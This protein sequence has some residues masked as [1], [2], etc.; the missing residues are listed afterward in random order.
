[1]IDWRNH[2]LDWLV[3][4]CGVLAVIAGV[5]WLALWFTGV[6]GRWSA[7][8]VIMKTNMALCLTLAGISLLLLSG[9]AA[10]PLRRWAAA[11]PAALVLL[12][13]VLTFSEHLFDY[14]LGIDQ[15]LATEPPGAMG[16]I[17]P[18]RFGPPGSISLVL[19]GLGLLALAAV[20][21]RWAAYL[22]L[23]VCLINL[24]PLIGFLYGITD[25]YR[26]PRFTGI[27]WPT[28]VTLLALGSGLMLAARDAGP[29][30]LL[31]RADPGGAMLRR[32]LP[33]V[34]LIPLV[35]G[36]V[37]I[38]AERAGLL[39]S[40][41]RM[42]LLVIALIVAFSAVVWYNAMHLSR[43]SA[44]RARTEEA[45][46]ESEERFHT[47]F[48]SM[49]EGFALCEMIFDDAG[50]PC[51][52]RYLELNRAWED[53]TG[54]PT[55]GV[56][57]KRVREILPNI[58]S[59]WIEEYGKVVLTGLP[60]RLE[61][62][63]QDVDRYIQV[64][65]Y[66][67]APG[68]FAAIFS[69]VTERKQAEAERE[70][71][72]AEVQRRAAELTATFDSIAD[73]LAIYDREG[74]L[75]FMNGTAERMIGYTPAERALSLEERVQ[76]VRMARPDGTPIPYE[77]S[78]NYRA[79]QG[80]TVR[81][82]VIVLQRQDRS[83]WLSLSAAP[84]RMPDGT[85]VGSVISFTDITPLHELREHER[86][87]L[88]ILAHNLRVPATL[89]KGNLELLL[90]A[91]QPHDLVQPHRH[92]VDALHSGLQRMNT[93]IDDFLLVTR[94]EEGKITLN[95]SPVA[96]DAYLP[97]F[98]RR[99]AQ[100]LEI[101]RI[102]LDVSA[103][104]PPLQADPN[105]LETILLN[106]LQNA[107][108]FS[109]PE[110]PIQVAAHRQ[111]GEVVISVTDHGIGIAPDDLP[112]IFDRFYRVARIRRAEGTGLGLYITK[113]L[114]EA[115]GGRIWAESEEGKG[116]TFSFT[117]PIAE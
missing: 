100:V 35:L 114:V 97:D 25:F 98:L 44:D 6:A 96:L 72:L 28:V 74:V 110:T 49:A 30:A 107:Q 59:Y 15:L 73:G 101:A 64:S 26:L 29:M 87:Y 95:S 42:G 83:L 106:L 38:Q 76:V 20:R 60:A 3:R 33:A 53:Q 105:L 111:N 52:W 80:E 93:M 109:Q 48:N 78:P 2:R 13:G 79:L 65:A 55:G 19:L 61:N 113:R 89:I 10:S 102:H 43:T 63:V 4:L 40:T 18:N 51:D 34:I 84:I 31:T 17:S 11:L 21:R 85:R 99:F 90:E 66:R 71:L 32:L 45:L 41:G 58:E 62:Y 67:P 116:S 117:L 50:K 47:L 70:R 46:R 88:Y 94:L 75:L 27:A 23:A 7:E 12:I 8:F 112:H 115:H 69:D 39:E 36:F 57:G 108:K 92:L 1:M 5:T 14:N 91:L 82:E 22:G 103:D 86:R 24:A 81:G 16:T 37:M 77:A 68:Q 9:T 54:L 104:L 56:V